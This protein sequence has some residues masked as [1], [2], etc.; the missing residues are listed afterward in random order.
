[1]TNLYLAILGEARLFGNH[2]KARVVQRQNSFWHHETTA[3]RVWLEAS[4]RDTLERLHH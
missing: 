3:F 2:L 4:I 1:M